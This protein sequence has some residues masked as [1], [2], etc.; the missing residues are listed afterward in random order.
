[1]QQKVVINESTSVETA[2]A[3]L[4]PANVGRRRWKLLQ[5]LGGNV[6]KEP[7]ETAAL[8]LFLECCLFVYITDWIAAY[9]WLTSVEVLPVLRIK[10]DLHNSH[11]ILKQHISIQLPRL[12]WY[13]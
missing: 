10:P 7:L 9:G 2:L 12:S 6:V 5:N 13:T 3:D 11:V 1:M 4:S 8:V